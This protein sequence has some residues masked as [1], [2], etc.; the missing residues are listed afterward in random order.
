MAQRQ[1]MLD[2]IKRNLDILKIAATR[3]ANDVTLNNSSRVI[4]YVD[5]DIQ[6]PMGG[7][8]GTI[9]PFLG[10]GQGNPG[11]LKFKGAGGE[12]TIAAIV[13]DAETLRVLGVLGNFAN[14]KVIE[15]GD[16]TAELAAIEGHTDLIGM[17]Q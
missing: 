3:N 5:A 10:I 9:N 12:N 1:Q 2:K 8:D 4:S 17:G 13:D 15:A 16:T 11:K 6:A 7:I 14:D